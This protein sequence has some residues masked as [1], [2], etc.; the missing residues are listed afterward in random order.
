MAYSRMK[1]SAYDLCADARSLVD[2]TIRR[3]CDV[4]G[5]QLHALNV[6]TNHVHVVVTATSYRPETVRDQFKAWC[7]RR[8][9]EAGSERTNFWTEGGSCRWINQEDEMEPA[10]LYVSEAQDRKNRDL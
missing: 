6:R 1:E 7:S 8:L 2:E 3:H 4:R 9:R 10:V 5:W